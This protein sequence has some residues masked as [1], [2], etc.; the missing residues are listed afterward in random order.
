MFTSLMYFEAYDQTAKRK[1]HMNANL[2][3][4][5]KYEH[6]NNA[7]LWVYFFS[8]SRFPMQRL[9]GLCCAICWDT[10]REKRTD[11]QTER[12]PS[13]MWQ[14]NKVGKRRQTANT[15]TPHAIILPPNC[16][17]IPFPNPRWPQQAQMCAHIAQFEI[18]SHQHVEWG[19]RMGSDILERRAAMAEKMEAQVAALLRFLLKHEVRK[20]QGGRYWDGSDVWIQFSNTASDSD[21]N[22]EPIKTNFFR[23][24]TFLRSSIL[25][26]FALSLSFKGKRRNTKRLSESELF[27]GCPRLHGHQVQCFQGLVLQ[28]IFKVLKLYF[29]AFSRFLNCIFKVLKF[30][31]QGLQFLFYF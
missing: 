10:E 11:T 6:K 18:V 29:Q 31:F 26:I 30:Y 2:Q 3:F 23:K 24:W 14:N 13:L 9:R 1:L 28:L 4:Y 21:R 12:S 22:F 27:A 25:F 17:I 19:G 5:I 7:S 8:P 16:F 15:T 20:L